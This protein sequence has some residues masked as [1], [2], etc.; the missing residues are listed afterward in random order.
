MRHGPADARHNAGVWIDE[1]DTT[2]LSQRLRVGP[3]ELLL[4]I[5]GPW[6]VAE[7]FPEHESEQPGTLF[8]GRAGPSAG[9]LVGEGPGVEVTVGKA[10]GEWQGAH[11]LLW[12]VIEPLV[13]VQLPDRDSP[14]AETDRLLEDLAEAVAAAVAAKRSALVVCRYCGQLVAP[15]HALDEDTCHACGSGVFGIVY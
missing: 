3:R 15:E 11:P 7:R 14:G 5:G 9:I 4:A 2:Q 1:T 8:V 6:H 12:T 10:V 13:R